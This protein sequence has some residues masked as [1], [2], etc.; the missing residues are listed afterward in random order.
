MRIYKTN[1]HNRCDAVFSEQVRFDQGI[2]DDIEAAGQEAREILA[3][4]IK[5]DSMECDLA[6]AEQAIRRIHADHELELQKA[7]DSAEHENA[8]LRREI[9]RLTPIRKKV[10]RAV[11]AIPGIVLAA[12]GIERV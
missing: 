9:E 8:S 3:A 6:S 5:I 1:G 11:S 2:A 10:R 7:L 4:R 12:L